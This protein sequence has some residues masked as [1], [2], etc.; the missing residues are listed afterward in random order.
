[1]NTYWFPSKSERIG[2][3]NQTIPT[4]N[5]ETTVTH[6]KAKQSSH[7]PNLRLVAKQDTTGLAACFASKEQTLLPPLALVQDA[8]ASIDE[9]M[10]DAARAGECRSHGWLFEKWGL[11]DFLCNR[12]L[13][14]S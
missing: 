11:S 6:R 12:G 5:K 9:L 4:G 8:K 10:S 3:A 14:Y 7:Q 13:S 2:F 1:L